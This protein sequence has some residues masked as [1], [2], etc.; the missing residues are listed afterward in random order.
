MANE[1]PVYLVRVR[2][3]PCS[4]CRA[5]PYSCAHHPRQFAHAGHD[6]RRAHD[7]YAIPLCHDCHINLHALAGRFRVFDGEGLR[8]WERL[9]VEKTQARLRPGVA[10]ELPAWR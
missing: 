6:A 7:H 3:L 5:R 8:A 10:V 9:Q 1:D 4:M 2:G